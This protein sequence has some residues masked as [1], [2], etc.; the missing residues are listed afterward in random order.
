MSWL[1]RSLSRKFRRL[2]DSPRRI[3]GRNLLEFLKDIGGFSGSI[4]LIKFN[5]LLFF[6]IPR[7]LPNVF[8]VRRPP[9]PTLTLN[10][11]GGAVV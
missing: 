6:S 2:L 7:S 9:S 4:E 5:G 10:V 3:R 11:G 8:K 1:R